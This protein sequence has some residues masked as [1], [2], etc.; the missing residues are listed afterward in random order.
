MSACCPNNG[1]CE[2]L[3]GEEEEE[4]DKRGDHFSRLTFSFK[5]GTRHRFVRPPPL[6]ICLFPPRFA[7]AAAVVVSFFFFAHRPTIFFLRRPNFFLNINVAFF[8]C[9]SSKPGIFLC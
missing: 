6:S 3:L 7:A 4:E 5:H 2:L 9:V 8:V 1:Q